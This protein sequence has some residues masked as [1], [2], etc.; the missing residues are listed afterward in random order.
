M[1]RLCPGHPFFWRR[2]DFEQLQEYVEAKVLAAVADG[3]AASA[4]GGRRR[5]AWMQLWCVFVEDLYA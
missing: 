5:E 4:A 3:A 2:S 1:V